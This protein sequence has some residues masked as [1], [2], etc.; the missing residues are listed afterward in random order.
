[1]W[2]A[3]CLTE[4]QLYQTLNQPMLRLQIPERR[5]LQTSKV[6]WRPASSNS[7]RQESKSIL[8]CSPVKKRNLLP[9]S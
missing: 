8:Y 4:H 6:S 7:T 5:F 3:S 2:V 9:S 1:M